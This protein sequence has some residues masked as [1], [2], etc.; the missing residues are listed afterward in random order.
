MSVSVEKT[1]RVE[2]ENGAGYVLSLDSDGGVKIRQTGILPQTVPLTD[3]ERGVIE[4]GSEWH[5]GLF[6]EPSGERSARVPVDRH[7]QAG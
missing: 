6:R 7:D 4:L 3:L 2:N 5:P 1:V